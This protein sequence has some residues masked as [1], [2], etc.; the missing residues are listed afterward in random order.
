MPH[1]SINVGLKTGWAIY[2]KSKLSGEHI[3]HFEE[4]KDEGYLYVRFE[5]WLSNMDRLIGGIRVISYIVSDCQSAGDK[6]L[7]L[8][9]E[10]ILQKYAVQEGISI[11]NN[12]KI[13]CLCL[14]DLPQ[15][16]NDDQDIDYAKSEGWSPITITEAKAA[17]LWEYNHDTMI[18]FPP[19]YEN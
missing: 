11:L 18:N 6:T 19:S 8:G 10:A 2:T 7:H 9:L 1:L 3:L 15:F 16:H 14:C 5:K 17:L 4:G 12:D 13:G